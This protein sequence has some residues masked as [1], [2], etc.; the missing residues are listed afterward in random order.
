MNNPYFYL[1]IGILLMVIGAGYA[2]SLTPK[3]YECYSTFFL[4]KSHGRV[5]TTV[6]V[7]TCA[8]D[9]EVHWAPSEICEQTNQQ[10][11]EK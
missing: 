7:C 10:P 1:V 4:A 6:D 5:Q 11:L 9:G 3:T 8:I 2:K